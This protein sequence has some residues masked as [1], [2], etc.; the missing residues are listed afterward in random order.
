MCRWA[1]HAGA[2][3]GATVVAAMRADA[4][5]TAFCI[6]TDATGVLAQP[7]RDLWFANSATTRACRT[8]RRDERVLDHTART[9]RFAA[10][11]LSRAPRLAAG[12]D[13]ASAK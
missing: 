12:V 3:L 1:E 8:G 9:P 2:T 4:M 10:A 13:E 5:K 11:R 7:A 6:S